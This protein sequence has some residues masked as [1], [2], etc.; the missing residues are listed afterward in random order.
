METKGENTS[1]FHE[2]MELLISRIADNNNNN[3]NKLNWYVHVQ[4]MDEEF[5]KG[6]HLQDEEREDLKI[7]A[8]GMREREM[9]TWSGSTKRERERE[10]ERVVVSVS[11]QE[12]ACL[13]RSS[14]TILKVN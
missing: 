7:R 6:T 2:S 14:S 13:I 11:N 12:V 5:W 9:A 8:E 1:I 10:R 3:N 4:R